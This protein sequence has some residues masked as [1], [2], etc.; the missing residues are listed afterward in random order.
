MDAAPATEASLARYPIDFAFANPEP[1]TNEGFAERRAEVLA[2]RGDD[3]IFEI[4][5]LYFEGEEAPEGFA[6]MGLAR[7]E[8]ARQLLVPDLPAERVLKK[9]R[10]VEAPEEAREG[11]FEAL[12]FAWTAREAAVA[13]TFEDLGDRIH[14]RFPFNSDQ[15]EYDPEVNS[16]LEQ[17]ADR[18]QEEDISLVI[19]G[20]TDNVGTNEVN[21]ELGME[22]AQN[23]KDYLVGQGA[24]ADNIEVVSQGA[25]V[26][27]ASNETERG[28]HEN[29]RVEL[30]I[31]NS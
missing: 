1:F 14:I 18:L 17:L 19:T 9:A 7:A 4:T 15:M 23:V 28:R 20:H 30:R 25:R 29:R 16:Y 2:G 6:N 31:I 13:E 11:Y 10:M 27:V 3:N 8:A 24:P 22:R 26:P 21:Q 12:R 5:G